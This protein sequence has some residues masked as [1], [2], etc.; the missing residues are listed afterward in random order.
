MNFTQNNACYVILVSAGLVHVASLMMGDQM[1]DTYSASAGPGGMTTITVIRDSFSVVNQGVQVTS[2][3]GRNLQC[4]FKF[5][6]VT[7][8]YT[9]CSF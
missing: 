9:N 6:Q 8:N 3:T 2:A 1:T 4:I 5:R 7:N